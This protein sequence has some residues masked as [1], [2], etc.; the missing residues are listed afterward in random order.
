MPE[1]ARALNR[2]CLPP[3]H[4]ALSAQPGGGLGSDIANAVTI[5]E[6]SDHAV[7]AM[8]AMASPGDSQNG[9]TAFVRKA[10]EAL[11]AGI[12]L[13]LIDLFPPSLRNPQGIHGAVSGEDRDADLAL[14]ENKPLTCVAYF[15]GSRAE[16]FVELV[17]VGEAW[18]DMAL[19][20]MRERYVPVPLEATYQTAWDGMPA[21]WRELLTTPREQVDGP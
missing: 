9:L 12:H 2:G 4:S 20:L 3:T 16:A 7:V 14:A 13:L 21:Y 6:L 1:I 18:P 19:F 5:H 10:R 15:G 17:A 11:A 8:V